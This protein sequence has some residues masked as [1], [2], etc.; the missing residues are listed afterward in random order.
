[1]KYQIANGAT[2]IQIGTDDYQP[3]PDGTWLQNARGTAFAWP[4]FTYAKVATEAR[5]E[6]DGAVVFRYN[7]VDFRV[8]IDAAT[9]RYVRYTLNSAGLRVT[10]TYSAFDSAPKILTP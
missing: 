7:D 4:N 3:A 2:S 1:M 9:G 5:L 10:G 8:E 6:A